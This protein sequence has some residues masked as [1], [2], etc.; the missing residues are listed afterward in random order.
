MEVDN[1]RE[2]TLLEIEDIDRVY[3]IGITE[4]I[5]LLKMTCPSTGHI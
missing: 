3:V 4:P 1:W 2:Y 5:I